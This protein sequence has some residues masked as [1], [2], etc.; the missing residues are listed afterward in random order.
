M[1]NTHVFETKM[2]D[3]MQISRYSTPVYSALAVFEEREKL[4]RGQSVTRPYLDVFEEQDYSRGTDLT[5]PDKTE[6]NETLTITTA[7]AT[8]FAIDDLDEVQSNFNL[9]AQ[10][11]DR[12]MR[13]LEKAV[14]AD[15]LSEVTNAASTVDDSDLGG[16]AGGGI[17]LDS[18]NVLRV[19]NI[20]LRKL[21]LK[22]VNVIGMTDPRPNVGNIK[23]GGQGGY[24]VVNPYFNEQLLV[25]LGGR[26]TSDGD[27]VGKNGYAN[28]YSGFDNYISTN[29]YWVGVLGIATQPTDG[30]TVTINSVTFTFKTVLGSTAGNVL[31]GGSADAANTNLAALINAPGTTTSNGVALSAANQKKMKRLTATTDT[32]ANT[33]T[34]VAKGWGY[35]VVAETFTDLTDTWTSELAYQ[36]FGVKGGVDMVVQK[37]PS[38]KVSDIPKQFG[39]YVKPHVLYGKKMFVEGANQTVQVKLNSASWA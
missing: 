39:S 35:I 14:D 18:S 29:G 30:D 19:Y 8:P 3:R 17:A 15:F 20:V 21:Q 6:T 31:I 27:M 2:S 23:P 33:L 26:E 28:K 13:A 37:R 4:R 1:A 25:A 32:D 38:V 36:M 12:A 34:L 10:Y 7:K 5:I 11:S 9:M 24:A 22:D 16:T